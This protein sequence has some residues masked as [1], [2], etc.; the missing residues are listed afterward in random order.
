MAAQSRCAA[1]PVIVN[2]F[3]QASEPQDKMEFCFEKHSSI[4]ITNQIQDQIK[5]AVSMG[6]LREGDVLPS[7]RDVEKQTGINRN[8]I[9]KAY[10]ALRRS[11]LLMLIRGKGTVVATATASPGMMHRNCVK[12]ANEIVV[13]SRSWGM[14]PTAFARFL[15]QHAQE[16]ERKDPFLIFVDTHEEAAAEMAD[17]ISR[18]WQVPVTGIS[19]NQVE[20]TLKRSSAKR[21]LL[22]SQFL[23]E[24]VQSLA[25]RKKAEVIAVTVRF[26]EQTTA[27]LD[28][29]E[30]GSSVVYIHVPQPGHRVRFITAHLCRFMEPR[31]IVISSSPVHDMESIRKLVNSSEYDWYLIGPAVRGDVPADIRLHSRVLQIQ[32]QIDPASLEVARVK[33]GVII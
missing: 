30:A 19:C 17:E 11:G 15:N 16:N 20:G 10:L 21:K 22:V 26:S 14:A 8:Q 25:S 3:M 6:I 32:P 2:L 31:G 5:I 9:H 33:A 27:M 12:L 23:Y 29:I 7:I 28:K 4:S 1:A 24:K 13:K 18:L